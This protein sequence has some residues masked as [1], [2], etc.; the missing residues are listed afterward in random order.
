MEAAV[1]WQRRSSDFDR[2]R[3]GDRQQMLRSQVHRT[4]LGIGMQKLLGA[5]APAE[6]H[7]EKSPAARWR[8]NRASMW[9]SRAGRLYMAGLPLDANV[10]FM[11]VM[12]TTMP[13]I[14]RG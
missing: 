12:A 6:G 9:R 2:Q 7:S 8:R 14:G 5:F 13:F 4:V 1:D 3:G 10:Q 11:T